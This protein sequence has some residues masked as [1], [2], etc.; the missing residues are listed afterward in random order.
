MLKKISKEFLKI[1]FIILLC[2]IILFPLYYLL[3]LAFTKSSDIDT[4]V[5]NFW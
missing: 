5:I 1:N 4:G 2:I 3:V